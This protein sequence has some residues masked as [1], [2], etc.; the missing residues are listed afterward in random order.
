[1]ISQAF[2]QIQGNGKLR[3][4]EQL[5]VDE[6]RH[7]GISIEFYTEKS[8]RRR[9]LALNLESLVVGDMPCIVGAL[10][11]LA[12]PEPVL[13]DYP[14]SDAIITRDKLYQVG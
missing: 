1:M 12:I 8:I 9:Q 10:Q 7:R 13:N 11:Q 2:I 4:E 3:L 5:V 6:L 14:R